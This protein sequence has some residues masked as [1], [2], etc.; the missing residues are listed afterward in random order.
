MS[1]QR[2]TD[3]CI[4]AIEMKKMWTRCEGSNARS[5]YMYPAASTRSSGPRASRFQKKYQWG[6]AAYAI[7]ATFASR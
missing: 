5:D 1:V 3:S 6:H 2:F 4:Y 7:P